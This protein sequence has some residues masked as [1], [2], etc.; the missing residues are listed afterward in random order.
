M[1]KIK[2]DHDL[3][4]YQEV[5]AFYEGREP[6]RSTE[7][8]RRRRLA[9]WWMK[10]LR[11]GGMATLGGIAGFLIMYVGMKIVDMVLG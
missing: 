2:I 6:D 1:E 9:P 4:T 11:I 3:V 10:A 8:S 7:V 5:L